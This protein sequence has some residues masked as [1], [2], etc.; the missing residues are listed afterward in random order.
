MPVLLKTPPWSIAACDEAMQ[1]G[2]TAQ[3]KTTRMQFLRDELADMVEA[4]HWLVLPYSAV[5]DMLL[6]YEFHHWA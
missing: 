3:P 1:Y 6:T 2:P 4:G 5:Q